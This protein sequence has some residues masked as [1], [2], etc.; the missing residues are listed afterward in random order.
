MPRTTNTITLSLPPKLTKKIEKLMKEEQRTR[1]ELLREALRRYIE[2]KEWQKILRYGE[3]R[4][5]K[6][7]IKKE[8]VE[9]LIDEAR[10]ERGKK[11]IR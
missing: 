2:E 3:N 5:K 4:A 8:D 9:R 6:F 11:K 10:T 1:S 7:G